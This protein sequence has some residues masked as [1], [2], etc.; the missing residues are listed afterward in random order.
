V[1]QDHEQ[2]DKLAEKWL[3]MIPLERHVSCFHI[4]IARWRCEVKLCL[5]MKTSL[6]TQGLP[7]PYWIVHYPGESPR[8]DAPF[9]PTQTQIDRIL[10]PHQTTKERN[11]S[12]N[13]ASGYHNPLWIRTCYSP[14]LQ[15][16]YEEIYEA[17]LQDDQD[18]LL[19]LDNEE[20]YG[21]YG[22]DW[23]RVF[24]RLPLV[25]DTALYYDDGPDIRDYD[26]EPPDDER[27]L[28]IHNASIRERQTVYLIDKQALKS[29]LVKVIFI[30][31]HGHT[32]WHN[33]IAPDVVWEFEANYTNGGMLDRIQERLDGTED[34]SLL[35][36]GAP[37]P[38][39][40]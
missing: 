7:Q 21:D 18:R 12:N 16:T 36:P 30:D 1:Q 33:T 40:G 26:A 22:E 6:L 15:P 37:L 38:Y 5:K 13:M 11:I 31:D 20:L 10:A 4:F 3:S 35:Q 14:D 2:W 39:Y 19:V 34:D 24:L 27:F 32:V 28:P 29:N 8:P 23:A 25:P 17:G 9:L